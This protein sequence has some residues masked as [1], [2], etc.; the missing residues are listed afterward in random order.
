M[1]TH[2]L[3]AATCLLVASSLCGQGIYDP[4][5]TE[6]DLQH[7]ALD[8]SKPVGTLLGRE[9]VGALGQAIYEIPIVVPPGTRGMEPQLSIAYDDHAGNGLLGMGWT[10]TG[11]SSI[12][13]VGQDYF[14]DGLPLPVT[15]TTA[16]RLAL[17]GKR[18]LVTNGQPYGSF[19]AVYDTEAASFA[20]ISPVGYFG[21]SAESFTMVTK[22]GMVM[23]FGGTED[24]RVLNAMGTQVLSWRVS[25]VRDAFGNYVDYIYSNSLSESTLSSIVYTGNDGPDAFEPYCRLDLDYA[26]RSDLNTVYVGAN[27]INGFEYFGTGRSMTRLLERIRIYDHE[28][29]VRTYSMRYTLRDGG[30][31]FLQEIRLSGTDPMRTLNSTF[32]VYH[33]PAE[34]FSEQP[35]EIQLPVDFHYPIDYRVGDFNGNGKS[36][37]LAY[38]RIDQCDMSYHTR[39]GAYFDGSTSISQV[40]IL[41]P[42]E[43]CVEPYYINNPFPATAI[44][45]EVVPD[46]HPFVNMGHVIGGFLEGISSAGGGMISSFTGGPNMPAV[47]PGSNPM[48]GISSSADYNGDGKE[49]VVET[50]IPFNAVLGRFAFDQ[51]EVVS[52]GLSQ[53]T[54]IFTSQEPDPFYKY[55]SRPGQF[56]LHGDMTGDGRADILGVFEKPVLGGSTPDHKLF[57]WSNGAWNELNYGSLSHFEDDVVRA[58]LW[59]LLDVNGDG[60]LDFVAFDDNGDCAGYQQTAMA[61]TIDDSWNLM[62]IGESDVWI[63]DCDEFHVLPA[64]FNGDGR[65]DLLSQHWDGTWRVLLSDGIKYRAPLGSYP[66]SMPGLNASETIRTGDYDGDGLG[67]IAYLDNDGDKIHLRLSRGFTGTEVVFSDRI[68]ELDNVVS[69]IQPC[70]W[71]GD[72]RTDLMVYS[73]FTKPSLY[74]FASDDHSRSI[75]MISNGLGQTVEFEHS[76]LTRADVAPYGD[77]VIGTYAYPNG[78]AV[79]PLE[80]VKSVKMTNGVGGANEARYLYEQLQVHRGGRG[81]LGFKATSVVE[82]ASQHRVRNENDYSA[83]FGVMLPYKRQT[84]L[85]ATQF[86]FSGTEQLSEETT[87]A[88]AVNVGS[89]RFQIRSS[90]IVS[91]DFLIGGAITTVTNSDWDAHGNLLMSTVDKAGLESITTSTDYVAA[92]LSPVPAKPSLVTTTRVRPPTAAVSER[93]CHSYDPTTGAMTSKN[94]FCGSGQ[95]VDTRF[96]QDAYGNV[97]STVST[98]EGLEYA[99]RR[100]E[101][102]EYDEEGRYPVVKKTY[103]DNGSENWLEERYYEDTPWGLPLKTVTADGLMHEKELDEFGQV[104]VEYAP[105]YLGNQRYSFVYSRRFVLADGFLYREDIESP[106]N[107]ITTTWH[108]D[109]GRV[110][111]QTSTSYSGDIVKSTT[112][113]DALGRVQLTTTPH[114]DSEAFIS[115]TT[116]YDEYSRPSTIHS[117]LANKTT[118]F[119]YTPL[120]TAMR[121]TT[122]V[123][124]NGPV[125]VSSRTVDATGKLID[126]RDDGGI[127]TYQYNGWGKLRRVQRGGGTVTLN[128]YDDYG[129][130]THSSIQDAGT[131]QYVT[132]PFG[133]TTSYKDPRGFWISYNYDNLGRVVLRMGDDDILLYRYYYEDGRFSNELVSISSGLL[134]PVHFTY[135]A[136]LL[137]LSTISKLIDGEEFTTSLEYDEMDR[138][139]RITYP[140][141][142]AVDRSYAANGALETVTH[143]GEVLFDAE[144]MNGQGQYTQYRLNDGNHVE[145]TYDRGFPMHYRAFGVA[146]AQDLRMGFDLSTGNVLSRTDM[147][148]LRK[149][150][151]TYDELNR[152]TG[153]IV[154]KIDANEQVISSY[155][156]AQYVFD[157][158]SGDTRGNLVIKSD[159]GLL[160]YSG[161]RGRVEA[162]YNIDFPEPPDAPPAVISLDEQLI[163]YTSFSAP[164]RITEAIGGVAYDLEF[165]YGSD[166]ERAKSVLKKNG[167]VDTE[168]WYA[169]SY[170]RQRYQDGGVNVDEIHYIPGG[171]GICAVIVIHNGTKTIHSA[172]KDH[173]GSITALSRAD[174][175]FFL[176]TAQQNFD[177]W[178][179]RRDPDTWTYDVVSTPPRWLF[180]GYTGHEMLDAFGL[181]N[182]NARLYDSN[183]GRMLGADD[184]VHGLTSSQSYNRYSYARNNPLKFTDPSGNIAISAVQ[185]LVGSSAV[186]G[187]AGGL[188]GDG[189]VHWAPWNWK[190]TA[191]QTAGIGMMAGLGGATIG[192]SIDGYFNSYFA[193]LAY[194]RVTY[195][196]GFSNLNI[197]AAALEGNDIGTVFGRGVSGL[198]HGA[199]FGFMEQHLPNKGLRGMVAGL[200]S[201]TVQ[202]MFEASD[203]GLDM[204]HVGWNAILGGLSGLASGPLHESHDHY[205]VYMLMMGAL[206]YHLQNGNRI[207]KYTSIGALFST[208]GVFTIA[209]GLV[210]SVPYAITGVEG[211]LAFAGAGGLA[212]LIY[213]AYVGYTVTGP[214]WISAFPDDPY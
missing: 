131:T 68:F 186:G 58:D 109:L 55:T 162:A 111:K 52:L 113:Y 87:L 66:V 170:E 181:I 148:A 161:T 62:L 143:D 127:L 136:E 163:G 187:Y 120:G 196:V 26:E 193:S 171:D 1:L 203:N 44:P 47:E 150:V 73:N 132:D 190:S 110:T 59:T 43:Q 83:S 61:F 79:V 100:E 51:I 114:Q 32:I 177:A 138:V 173:L 147:L 202:G 50:K 194:E 174:G 137:R 33:E 54:T 71:N 77:D 158:S 78:V 164:S 157:G 63:S 178:G 39:F 206:N 72:G 104:V 53:S 140:S 195:A 129:R 180:R 28:A 5:I 7:R 96:S 74:S 18:L 209:G 11:F 65:T 135:D 94:T 189:F 67:D 204:N 8:G 93:V 208:M 112:E 159:V 105:Y 201:G 91:K 89:N 103:F 139:S 85:A 108:D 97:Y 185:W 24:S 36:D 31:S 205:G 3:S 80:V 90:S 37:I 145:V 198:V 84:M 213:G 49:D 107:G 115:E 183:L 168:R 151:F 40:T 211:T 64:D 95:G 182:M 42:T 81:A 21:N 134:P 4:P 6:S 214:A 207:K 101:R 35:G 125:Q 175:M 154:H 149:E 76:Y 45:W 70:D 153:S 20:S 88:S 130:M 172:Y 192:V 176:F 123:E 128:V 210:G 23:I 25:Q 60:R 34:M 117:D 22:D 199:A 30:R 166:L 13:R 152:L 86:P 126:A 144:D 9:A 57:L 167:D 29:H 156:P 69:Q 188:I 10:L 122:S 197:V 121:V 118:T 46:I 133:L 16:D 124:T 82:V 19:S 165:T 119:T 38:P 146:P 141:G 160:G 102:F 184:F 98:Y 92:G 106:L 155:P 12:S 2:V 99:Q 27:Y 142:V 75:R 169:G 14:H 56:L 179:R 212:G 191:W 41:N 17:D 200:L 15:F 48:L 116:T